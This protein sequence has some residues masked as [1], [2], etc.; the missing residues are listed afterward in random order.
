MIAGEARSDQGEVWEEV[1]EHLNAMAAPSPTRNVVEASLRAEDRVEYYRKTID[2]P[3][4]AC[5][6]LAARGGE[7][8]R[9][10]R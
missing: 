2:L 8:T 5:G 7:V 3:S 9:G 1:E 6:F 10:S 4:G